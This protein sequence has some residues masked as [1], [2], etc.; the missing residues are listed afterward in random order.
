MELA[1]ALS[2]FAA[3]FPAELPD[4]TMVASL[5]LSTRYRRPLLV[6]LGV[7]AAFCIHVGVAVA[8]GRLLSLLPEAPVKFGVAL[9]FATGAVVLWRDTSDPQAETEEGVEE[10]GGRGARPATARAAVAGSF[11][12]ILLAEWGDLTQLATASMAART[13]DP[14]MVALGALTALWAVAAIAITA[15]KVLLRTL[16]LPLV[17]KVAAVVFATLAV[18]SVVDGLRAL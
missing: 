9:L 18:W 8:A 11:G 7:A 2:A 13:D 10:T 6:W 15:G 12:V 1:H 17:R 14:V 4:K 3:V 16:P 5:V